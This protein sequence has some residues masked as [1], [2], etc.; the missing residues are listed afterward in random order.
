M[1]GLEVRAGDIAGRR[2]SGDRPPRT[3]PGLSDRPGAPA[4][5]E[6]GRG[7]SDDPGLVGGPEVGGTIDDVP[8]AAREATQVKWVVRAGAGT[9]V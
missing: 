8:P 3:P 6:T 4:L 2:A 5:R 1:L 9:C 7:Y